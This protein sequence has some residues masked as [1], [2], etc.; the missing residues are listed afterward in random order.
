MSA[1]IHLIDI[2]GDVQFYSFFCPGCKYD[3]SFEV[4]RWTWNGS[5]EKPTFT[6]SLMC[7]ASIPSSRCHSFVTNGQIAFLPDCW[8]NLAGQ[9]VDLPDYES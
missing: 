5:L 9:T 2:R 6:P 7:N 4:P 1:K 8:H 3:H